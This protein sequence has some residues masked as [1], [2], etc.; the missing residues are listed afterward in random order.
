LDNKVFDTVDARCN[1]EDCSNMFTINVILS[2]HLV[3]VRS[4]SAQYRIVT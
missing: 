3:V 1:H 2:K 4:S